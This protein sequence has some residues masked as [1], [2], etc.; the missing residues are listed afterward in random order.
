MRIEY[1]GVAGVV[2][3][4]IAPNPVDPDHKGLVF[5]GSRFQQCYPMIYARIGPVGDDWEEIGSGFGA[6]PKSSGKR[7]S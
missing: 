2:E 6:S 1:N 4:R 3:F 5:N 7:K